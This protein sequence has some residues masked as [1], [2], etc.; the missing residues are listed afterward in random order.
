MPE[1]VLLDMLII[2]HKFFCAYTIL[3]ICGSKC[4][5]VPLAENGQKEL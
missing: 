5:I 4:D 1:I 3:W 2:Y